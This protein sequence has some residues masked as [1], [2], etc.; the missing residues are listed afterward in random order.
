M[1]RPKQP[2]PTPAELEVLQVLWNDGPATVRQVMERLSGVRPRG[3]TTALSLL[4]VM[5]GKGLVKRKPQG[6]AF[7][8]AARV[9]QAK[10]LKRLLG[11]LLGRAFQGS[12]SALVSHLLDH[13][14]PNQDEL[15]A[16]RSAIEEHERGQKGTP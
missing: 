13:A 11:D 15:R 1:A 6:R 5:H 12:S 7:L 4:D 2:H 16:I 14:S 9:D 3:Y 8:Y 10:T